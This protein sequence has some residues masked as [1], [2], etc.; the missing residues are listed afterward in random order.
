ML[1]SAPN[2]LKRNGVLLWLHSATHCNFTLDFTMVCIQKTA[3]ITKWSASVFEESRL[4][5]WCVNS[6]ESTSLCD[7]WNLFHEILQDEA[8]SFSSDSKC[9][10]LP[11]LAHDVRAMHWLL[12]F[13]PACLLQKKKQNT[14]SCWFTYMY[15]FAKIIK[16]CIP[17]NN[18]YILIFFKWQW[19][20]K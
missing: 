13:L 3:N 1:L 19:I 2:N 4:L 8:S 17:Y 18:L 10:I 20:E 16:N 11:T 14:Y 5:C 7:K 12:L 6:L 9:S 15:M